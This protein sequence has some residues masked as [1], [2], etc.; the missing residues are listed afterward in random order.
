MRRPHRTALVVLFAG[1]LASACGA[2]FDGTVYRGADFA[3]RVPARPAT[4]QPLEAEGTG[5]AFRDPDASATVAVSA[6]CGKDADDVPLTSLTQHLFIQFTERDATTEEVVP[7]DGREAQHTVMSAKLDGVPKKFDVW[8][9]KKDGCVYDLIFVAPP[10]RF[11]G[12][13]GAFRT[14]VSGFGT[15]PVK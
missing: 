3:F 4:W 7:F 13:V 6:R 8:V 15:V 1:G 9:M 14:F 12:G 5:L 10:D 11:D 2:P